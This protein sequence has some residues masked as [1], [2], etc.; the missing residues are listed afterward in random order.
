[1]LLSGLYIF[2][3]I[4]FKNDSTVTFSIQRSI[5]GL[6]FIVFATYLGAGNH[7]YDINGTIKSYLPPK[8]YQSNLIWNNN[9]EDAFQI[10]QTQNKNIFIDF[11]GDGWKLI[12]LI[13]LLLKT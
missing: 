8:K 5:I 7:G 3:L 6:A 1:M 10:A 13:L 2:G 4:K 12:F 11:T 9:L